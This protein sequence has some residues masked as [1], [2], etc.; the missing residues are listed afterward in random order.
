MHANGTC[1]EPADQDVVTFSYPSASPAWPMAADLVFPE[2]GHD[3]QPFTAHSDAPCDPAEMQ[4]C[5]DRRLADETARSFAEGH[6]RGM[7]ESRIAEDDAHQSAHSEE[8][9]ARSAELARLMQQFAGERDRYLER[10][11]TEV[12]RL[13]L[14]IAAR[15]LRREAQT[16]PLLL[17]GA[18]RVALGQ[19]AGATRL[20]LRVPAAHASLWN[21]A[22]ALLPS[23]T[24]RPEIVSDETMRLGECVLESELGSVDL[25]VPAQLAEIE[26]RLFTGAAVVE[27]EPAMEVEA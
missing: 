12:V 22:V 21:D 3:G 10:I 5:F 26:R 7:E 13:A 8:T 14:A 17:L 20:R 11:E 23:R 4:A 18:V 16:D 24:S 2:L 6:A 15:I 9:A 25:A 27:P 19:L 1:T